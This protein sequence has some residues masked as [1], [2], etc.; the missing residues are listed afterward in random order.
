MNAAMNKPDPTK[1][2]RQTYGAWW[3]RRPGTAPLSTT[4]VALAGTVALF[5]AAFAAMTTVRR[6]PGP[7]IAPEKPTVVRLTPPP[8]QTDVRP[9]RRPQPA[10]A[11]TAVP[12]QL[13]QP[14]TTAPPPPTVVNPTTP[15]TQDTAAARG[16]APPAVAPSITILPPFREV[17][18]F[19]SSADGAGPVGVAAPSAVTRRNTPLTPAQKDSIIAA[20]VALVPYEALKRAIR[21]QQCAEV[22]R[23]P[24]PGLASRGRAARLPGEPVFAPTMGGNVAVGITMFTIA[25]GPQRDRKR[26]AAIDTDNQFRLRRLQDRLMLRRDSMRADSLRRDS[27]ARAARTPF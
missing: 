8:P 26:D 11:P 13:P 21:V 23:Q 10:P 1:A 9:I 15:P 27:L 6:P 25:V 22:D 3:G 16:A 4:T 24:A 17:P 7:T 5:T 2:A 18:T 12:N 19:P 14:V 20:T